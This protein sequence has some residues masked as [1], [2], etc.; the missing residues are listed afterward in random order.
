MTEIEKRLYQIK[1]RILTGASEVA[2]YKW[3]DAYSKKSICEVCSPKSTTFSQ[4]IKP[5]TIAELQKL[6]REA[7]YANGFG[8]W[9]EE[10]VL[11]PL[12]LKNFI[13][14]DEKILSISG[15][16]ETVG[17][18]DTDHRGGFLAGGFYK[19]S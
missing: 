12:W 17:G 19:E 15:K 5:I 1:M 7:L 9:N 3:S 16:D 4:A 14:Q 10:L 8:N 13:D 2:H 6:S 11:I 18:I